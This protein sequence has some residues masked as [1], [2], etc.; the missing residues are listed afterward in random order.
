[1]EIIFETPRLLIRLATP[2]D[3]TLIHSLWTDPRVMTHVGFPQGLRTSP[4]KIQAEVASRGS[5][6]FEQ[7]LIVVLKKTDQSI[8]QCKMGHPDEQGISETDIK[9]LPEFWG[10]GY[11][12]E[13]KRGLLDYLFTHTDCQ[14]VSATPNVNNIASIKMQ[15]AVGG[16]RIGKAVYEFP[17]NMQEYTCPVHHYVYHVYREKWQK[18]RK[19]EGKP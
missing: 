12:V 4:E 19:E 14:A 13:I 2:T 11:G 18:L 6:E 3:A 9:I 7:L 1:M 15:E 10:H 5:S 16:V 8:G 17:E